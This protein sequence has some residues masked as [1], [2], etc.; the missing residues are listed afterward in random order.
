MTTDGEAPGGFGSD[1][2]LTEFDAEGEVAEGGQII[3]VEM[4]CER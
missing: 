2:F 3:D 1:D 4:S